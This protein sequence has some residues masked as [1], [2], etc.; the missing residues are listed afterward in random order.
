MTKLR[1]LKPHELIRALDKAGFEIQRQK[2]SH[3]YLKHP[4]T[5]RRVPVYSHP[6][7]DIKRSTLLKIIK[8]AGLSESDIA[9]L[10]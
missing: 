8:A 6:G 1:I 10:L 7:T 4:V 5:G 9:R 2:G 3:I